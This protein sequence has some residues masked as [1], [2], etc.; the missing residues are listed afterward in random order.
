MTAQMR[1]RLMTKDEY[2]RLSQEA[3]FDSRRVQLI[4][5]ELIEMAARTSFHALA[6]DMTKDVL[7]NVFGD[8]YWVRAQFSL[9]LS[10]WSV[11][12]PDIAVVEGRRDQHS[13]DRNPTTA[14][15]SVEV[16]WSTL[17]TDRRVKG[18]LYAASGIADYW[19]VTLED[20]QL[21]VYREPVPDEREPLDFRY[22]SVTILDLEGAVSPLACPDARISVRDLI[23]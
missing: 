10:P 19:I 7:T 13:P 9:D 8:G 3:F 5:G 2:Y 23:P 4:N 14:V 12:D 18:S 20:R 15:L 1:Q 11:P 16:S 17:A 6:L 21:E 22:S